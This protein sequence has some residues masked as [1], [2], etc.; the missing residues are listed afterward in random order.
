MYETLAS[1]AQTGGLLY[2]VVIFVVAVVYAAWPKN[3]KTFDAAA[4]L[5]LSDKEPG[6]E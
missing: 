6:D 5:P 1:F 3:Q 2:F 4:R